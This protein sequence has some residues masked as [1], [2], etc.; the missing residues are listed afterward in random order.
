MT[1]EADIAGG[2]YK[3]NDEAIKSLKSFFHAADMQQGVIGR[4]AIR[5]KQLRRGRLQVKWSRESEDAATVE[6]EYPEDKQMEATVDA[7]NH[8]KIKPTVKFEL[9]DL[10]FHLPD[11]QERESFLAM[12]ENAQRHFRHSVFN[13]FEKT[14]N[15]YNISVE[16]SQWTDT[17][18]I[19]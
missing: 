19:N 12:D 9:S 8:Y 1:I 2:R 10:Q 15:K 14:L 3:I 16:H 17:P 5:L 7:G 18:T 11:D 4:A 13:E 6:Y